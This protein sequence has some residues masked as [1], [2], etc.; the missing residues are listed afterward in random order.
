M[1][2]K[3]IYLG[4]MLGA[5]VSISSCKK[6]EEDPFMSLRS[7]K[8]RLAGEW[9]IANGKTEIKLFQGEEYSYL[10][11]EE[12]DGEKL[13]YQTTVTQNGNTSNYSDQV[14]Y[15]NKIVFN[16]DQSFEFTKVQYYPNGQIQSNERSTGTWAFAL[17]N[18]SAEIKNKECVVINSTKVT[19]TYYDE[20]GQVT[21]QSSQTFSANHSEGEIIYLKRLSNKELIIDFESS[22]AGYFNNYQMDSSSSGTTTYQKK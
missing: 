19:F 7:R 2:K 21:D 5:L 18:K 9:D 3:L 8:A 12:F 10:R 4:C 16:K 14:K 22:V 11:T 15:E 17:K 6:G 1:M 20:N 13:K